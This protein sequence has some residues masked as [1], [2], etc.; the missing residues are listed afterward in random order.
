VRSPSISRILSRTAVILTAGAVALTGQQ[1]AHAKTLIDTWSSWDGCCSVGTFGHPNTSTYGQVITI[2]EGDTKLK[3]V[4][5]YMQASLG[6]G[7]LTYRSAVYTWDGTKAGEK[8]AHGKKKTVEVATGDPEFHPTRTRFREAKVEA[9]EQYVVFATIS[10]DYEETD[11][12]VSVNWPVTSGE[13][14]VLPGG[15]FVYIND[16]GNE[17]LWTTQAWEQI[18]FDNAFKAKLT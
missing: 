5:W 12:D 10:L 17:A 14:D 2:P 18:P 3:T 9:G 1:V 4:K 15:D 7:T 11:P 13:E 8:V 6:S 16:S